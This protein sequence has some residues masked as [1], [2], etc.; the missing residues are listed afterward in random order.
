[1]LAVHFFYQNSDPGIVDILCI[2]SSERIP[3]L[4]RRQSIN[5]DLFDERKRYLAVRTHSDS[6]NRRLGLVPHANLNYVARAETVRY[7]IRS[8]LPRRRRL[9]RSGLRQ[10]EDFA[11]LRAIG[12]AHFCHLAYL[13]LE[14]LPVWIAIRSTLARFLSRTGCHKRRPDNE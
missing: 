1:L 8:L 11:R 4:Q 2:L 3:Q 10:E 12:P 13:R 7:R 9:A 5:R 6:G 14:V